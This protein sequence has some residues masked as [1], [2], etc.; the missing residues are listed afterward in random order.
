MFDLQ[1]LEAQMTKAVRE[2]VADEVGRT[3]SLTAKTELINSILQKP[4]MIFPDDIMMVL[5]IGRSTAF[6]LA[7]DPDFPRMSKLGARSILMTPLFMSYVEG[8][9][10]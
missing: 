1:A 4:V 2:A 8:K 10:A 6:N 9:A 7:K 5:G 3:Q